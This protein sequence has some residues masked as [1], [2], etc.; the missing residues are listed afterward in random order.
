MGVACKA[1]PVVLMQCVKSLKETLSASVVLV[2]METESPALVLYVR[3]HIMKKTCSSL[4]FFK[5]IDECGEGVSEC[6]S[7][8]GCVNTAGAY[9]CYCLPGYDGDGFTCSGMTVTTEGYVVMTLPLWMDL[10]C[11]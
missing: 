10:R 9:K 7:S 6:S 11:G 2:S 1:Q 8:G 4:L 3:M 5:D